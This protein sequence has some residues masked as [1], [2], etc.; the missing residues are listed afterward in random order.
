MIEL[1]LLALD[2]SEFSELSHMALVVQVSYGHRIIPWF[3]LRDF[4]S[5]CAT[6]DIVSLLRTLRLRRRGKLDLMRNLF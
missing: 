3:Q 1:L 4:T 6:A 5:P 2:R